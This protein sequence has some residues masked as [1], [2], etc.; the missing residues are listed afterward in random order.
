MFWPNGPYYAGIMLDAFSYLLCSKICW[1][2]RLVPTVGIYVVG[3]TE[4]T[5]VKFHSFVNCLNALLLNG[6]L[7]A[8]IGC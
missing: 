2:N 5:T 4:V 6:M 8:T 7:S 3:N 1:H